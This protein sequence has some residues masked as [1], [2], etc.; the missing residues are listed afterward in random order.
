MAAAARGRDR[1]TREKDWSQI[2][3]DLKALRDKLLASGVFGEAIEKLD[4]PKARGKVMGDIIIKL[5]TPAIHK[6]QN[7]WDRMTQTH[8]NL[9]LAFALARFYCDY[10]HYPKTLDGLAP[11]Y[12]DHVP[13]DNFPGRR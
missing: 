8:D 6:M 5:M 1:P 10:G 11:K 13:A 4:D 9:R 3:N 12:L 7:A 2:E